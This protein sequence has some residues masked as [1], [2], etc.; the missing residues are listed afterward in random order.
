MK[1]LFIIALFGI[2]TGF[3]LGM[4]Y[5]SDIHKKIDADFIAKEKEKS[6]MNGLLAKPIKLPFTAEANVPYY[7]VFNTDTCIEDVGGWSSDTERSDI[8]LY[9]C[10]NTHH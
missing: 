4:N 8:K 10:E 1:L 7:I 9:G 3:I 6:Y 5:E 2:G